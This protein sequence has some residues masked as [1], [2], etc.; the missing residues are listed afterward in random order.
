MLHVTPSHTTHDLADAPEGHPVA[1]AITRGGRLLRPRGGPGATMTISLQLHPYRPLIE[2]AC[3]LYPVVPNVL[4]AMVSGCARHTL[5]TSH[6]AVHANATT[7]MLRFCRAALDATGKHSRPRGNMVVYLGMLV[8]IHHLQ[9]LRHIVRRVAVNVMDD[10]IRFKNATKRLFSYQPMFSHI[11]LLV[12]MW[13][14]RLI[15]VNVS[16]PSLP[17]PVHSGNHLASGS[18]TPGAGVGAI[19]SIGNTVWL[20]PKRLA[21]F[22]TRNIG[23]MMEGHSMSFHR[24]PCTGWFQPRRCFSLPQLYKIGGIYDCA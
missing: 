9:V 15:D 13:M 1:G 5:S 21:T 18:G 10:F 3:R 17:F 6:V 2:D 20:Y 24:V 4:E 16:R 12:C 19:P 11:P 7:R 8:P 22:F 23:G 14:I